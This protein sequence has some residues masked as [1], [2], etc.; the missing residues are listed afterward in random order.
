M[1]I[2]KIISEVI[3]MAKKYF[4]KQ[5]KKKSNPKLY[6]DGHRRYIGL[7]P[8]VTPR[9]RIPDDELLSQ[10]EMLDMTTNVMSDIAA[11][12]SMEAAARDVMARNAERNTDR[13]RF[14]LVDFVERGDIT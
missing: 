12:H 3:T 13:D 14:K 11:Q 2:T 9:F 7:N 1:V 4:K 8:C 5:A 10:K 6:P